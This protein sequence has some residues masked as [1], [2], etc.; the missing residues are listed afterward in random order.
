MGEAAQAHC[1]LWREGKVAP[2]SR[3]GKTLWLLL[4]ISV[5][6]CSQ[7]PALATTAAG[8]IVEDVATAQ[9][10]GGAVSSNQATF[11]VAQVAGV[12][13]APSTGSGAGY[14]GQ[15]AYYSATV[16]NAGNGTDTF[17]LS[18]TSTA[19]YTVRVYNANKVTVITDT[20]PLAPG[21]SLSCFVGVTIPAGATAT[22]TT[23]LT[24]S[25]GFNSAVQSSAVYTTTVMALPV[26]AFSASPVGGTAPLVV[27]FSDQSTGLPNSWNWNFGDGATSTT[28]NPS[29]VYDNA[30]TYTVSLTVANPGGQNT[31]TTADYINVTV[32]PPVA[33]FSGAPTS[34]SAPLTVSFSDKSTGQPTSWRWE[35]GDGGTSALQ[36]PSHAYAGAGSYSVSLTV[37]NAGGQN[38]VTKASYITVA[39]APPVAAFTA[40][41]L[42][43]AAP[44]TVSFTDQSTGQPSS[45]QWDFG[46]GVASTAQNPSHTYANVGSYTVSLTVANSGGENTVTRVNYINAT[47]PPPAAAFSGSPVS[48]TAP[49]T[50][51]FADESTGQP[52]SWLWEFGDGGTSTLQH[53]SHVY[54]G[55]GTYSVS[56]TAANVGGQDAV[57]KSAYIAVSGG[58]LVA[59]FNATPT[60]GLPTLTVSFIDQSSG[61]PNSWRW[62][63][64]DGQASSAQN[65]SH[66]YTVPG[67]YTVT[68]SISNGSEI[69]T[70]TKVAYVVVGFPDVPPWYWAYGEVMACLKAGVV[71]GYPD[72]KFHPN[73]KITRDQMAVFISRAIAGSDR[74]VPPGPAVPTF[75][76]VDESYWAYRYIEYAVAQQ[77]VVGYAGANY[78]PNLQVDRAQ[79]A[80]FISRAL[81]APLGDAGLDG[82]APPTTPTFSDVPPNYWAYKHIEFL[83]KTGA[84]VIKG[85]PNGQYYPENACTRDQLAIFLALAFRLPPP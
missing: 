18:V 60:S 82:Y 15:T 76:D 25:S 12:A 83:A 69:A 34:G 31:L 40:A 81:V 78:R 64:G 66:A 7:V 68:L 37:S 29:H 32:S 44:L 28:Q 59:Q 17:R 41:P 79:I 58:P 85:Y 24:V 5:L 70:E 45:W 67:A 13:V 26:A 39:V 65:P 35:F 72:M 8:T 30:G 84:G 14:P 75:R 1:W 46:D 43:G 56:L 27:N 23:T 52:T 3:L 61:Q 71:G 50:V 62:K 9:Y 4:L 47:V 33:A 38:A 21:G 55:A 16:S 20:G 49:L 11:T 73:W 77:V 48:G 53:P 6:A 36:H 63:F 2:R 22:D 51:N 74:D 19:G 80:V 10:D 54:T 57:T 42:S